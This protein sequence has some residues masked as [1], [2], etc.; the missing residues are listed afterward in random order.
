LYDLVQ[1]H[2]NQQSLVWGQVEI[3]Y[4][5]SGVRCLWSNLVTR[6]REDDHIRGGRT[7]KGNPPSTWIIN[8]SGDEDPVS[9]SW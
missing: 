3:S 9:Q 4:T 2:A 1:A 8:L 5:E 7:T 6:L